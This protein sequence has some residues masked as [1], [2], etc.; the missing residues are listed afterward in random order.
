MALPTVAGT[1]QVPTP[2]F[3]RKLRR[4]SDSGDPADDQGQR[5]KDAV[6]KLFRSQS[7]RDIS[8]YLVHND[9]DLRRVALGMNA[10]RVSLKEAVPFVAFL[11]AELESAAIRANPTPGNLP[12]AHANCLHHDI[13][14]TDEQLTQL[15]QSAMQSGRVA[16]NCSQGMM[17]DIITAAKAENCRTVTTEGLCQVQTCNPA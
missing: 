13:Q 15:C 12:C 16:G 2:A 8:I 3:V 14:A 17:K 9:E 11:P 4:R 5:V 1:L 6:D 10:G 7:E